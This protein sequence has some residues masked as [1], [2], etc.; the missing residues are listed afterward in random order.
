[1]ISNLL[2]IYFATRKTFYKTTFYGFGIGIG[3]SISPVA[4]KFFG[5]LGF[6]IISSA[7]HDENVSNKIV[8]PNI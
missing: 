2:K 4:C 5:S 6:S 8:I 3:G 1:M 7:V